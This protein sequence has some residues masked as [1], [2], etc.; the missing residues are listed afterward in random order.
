M[1]D[2]KNENFD[3]LTLPRNFYCTF[4]TEY[5]YH[6]AIQLSKFPFMDG[7]IHVT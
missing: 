3:L 1:T 5:A 6:K 4:H 7:E 2:F